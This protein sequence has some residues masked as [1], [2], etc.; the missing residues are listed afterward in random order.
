MGWNDNVDMENDEK[1]LWVAEFAEED[2]DDFNGVFQEK[3]VPE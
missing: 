2:L 3:E 1:S